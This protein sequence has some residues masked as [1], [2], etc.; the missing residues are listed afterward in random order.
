[1]E[2]DQAAEMWDLLRRDLNAVWER[3]LAKWRSLTSLAPAQGP[4]PIREQ[5][6]PRPHKATCPTCGR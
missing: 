5:E 6:A 1:M 2:N 3:H 4:P